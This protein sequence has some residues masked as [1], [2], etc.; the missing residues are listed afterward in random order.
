MKHNKLKALLLSVIMLSGGIFSASPLF[1]YQSP[2]RVLAASPA[3]AKGYILSYTR[4]GTANMK[5]NSM[6]LAY[7][8]DGTNFTSLNCNTGVLYVKTDYEEN[9]SNVAGI[10]KWIKEPYIFRMADGSFGVLAVREN[11]DNSGKDTS[12]V[13]S[14]VFFTSPD[15]ISY[16]QKGFLSLN[17]SQITIKN[18]SC[19]YDSTNAVYTIYW[20]DR[21]GNMYS[22]TTMDFENIS[23]PV[24]AS[25]DTSAPECDV[26]D[27]S[28]ELPSSIIPVS[29]DE[30]TKIKNKLGTITNTG[31]EEIS[32]T[33]KLGVPFSSANLP[34][35]KAVYS[36]GS[37]AEFH[38]D[39]KEEDLD[40]IDVNTAGD[41]EVSGTIIRPDYSGFELKNRADPVIIHNEDDGMYYF[42]STRDGGQTVLLLRKSDSILGLLNAEEISLPLGNL[43]GNLIWAPEL[44]KVGDTWYCYFASGKTWNVVQSHLI[45]CEDGDLANPDSWSAPVRIKNVDGEY[46]YTKGITLDMT[47]FEQNGTFYYIWAQRQIDPTGNSDL[48]IATFDP[49]DPTQITSDPVMIAQAEYGWEKLNTDVIEGPFALMHDGKIFVTY[50]GS[51]TDSTYCIGLLT[52]DQNDDLL[53]PTSWTKSNYPILKQESLGEPGPGHNSFTTDDDGNTILIYHYGTNGNSRNAR[54]RKVHWAFDGTP[55]LSM[56]AEDELNPKFQ[57]ITAVVH[58]NNPAEK[59]TLTPST[60]RLAIGKQLILKANVTPSNT[61]DQLTWSTSSPFIA[62]VK[63]GVVTAKTAGTVTITATCGS[64]SASCK[65][66]VTNPAVSLKLNKTSASL[67]VKKTIKLRARV[68]PS[69]TTDQVV[70][71]VSNQNA[72][73]SRTGV[74]TA[75]KPGA[76]LVTAIAGSCSSFCK[77]TIKAP[78]TKL[79]LN[80]TSLKLK[81]G[82]TYLLRAKMKPSYSTDKLKWHTNSKRIRLK[83]GM[84]TALKKGTAIVTV[85]TTSGKKASCTVT[86]K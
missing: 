22:N 77:I 36:D 55:V 11:I 81:V 42:I 54:V 56:L 34:K 27:I 13:G 16:T 28:D 21:D 80:K 83:S 5:T 17:S 44:H 53:D 46:L 47:E 12:H 86:V 71:K 39:W 69:N 65:I 6:H 79:T 9:P 20:Q 51:A 63:D 15:L 24:S 72:T 37:T 2:S 50:S 3:S 49:S 75:K 1:H 76:V 45:A 82:K 73:V 31:I 4:S 78:A 62:S 68:S 60:S 66:T 19:E 32:V 26:T 10:N 35:A 64:Q 84:I 8:E 67:K 74:V 29:Q 70:W 41:Y 14:V 43:N 18:P 7:S 33:S 48:Y 25:Y 23:E 52:A 38:V 85:K 59:I 30:L 58:I 57:N 40:Q 61:T